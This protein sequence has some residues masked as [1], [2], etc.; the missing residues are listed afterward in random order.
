M[1][2]YKNL[3]KSIVLK[4]AGKKRKCYHDEK[5]SISKDEWVLEVNEGMNKSSGYCSCCA[6]NMFKDAK[7][8]IIELEDMLQ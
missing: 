7:S 3:L 4:P 8:K 1:A 6:S 5:H 2:K